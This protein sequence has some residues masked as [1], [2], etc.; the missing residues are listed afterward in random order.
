V[1]AIKIGG[2]AIVFIAA[3]LFVLNLI[4]LSGAI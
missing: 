3:S 4:H 2:A 1:E